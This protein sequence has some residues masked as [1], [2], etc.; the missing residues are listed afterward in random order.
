MRFAV[1]G[2]D[3]SK[4]KITGWKTYDPSNAIVTYPTNIKEPYT[5]RFNI[6]VY[7]VGNR[8][9]RFP[10]TIVLQGCD[11]EANIITNP[12]ESAWKTKQINENPNRSWTNIRINE[13]TY[14][15]PYCKRLKYSVHGKDVAYMSIYSGT[16]LRYRSN[17]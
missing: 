15:N 2:T 10:S 11:N 16:Y 3:A 17:I 13:F 12:N 7:A 9:N 6:L 14:S 1:D 5:L 4:I 8:Y